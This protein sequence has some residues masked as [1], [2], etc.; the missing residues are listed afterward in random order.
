MN[1]R[2]KL[3]GAMVLPAIALVV[4][5]ATFRA[6]SGGEASATVRHDAMAAD[7]QRLTV[8]LGDTLRFDQ[9]AFTVNA[10][11]PVVITVRN[12]GSTNHDFVIPSMPAE[13]VVIRNEGG[14]THGDG[15]AIVGHPRVNGEVTVQ[16]TPTQ[17]G[18]YEFYCSVTGHKEAGMTGTIIVL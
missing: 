3:L 6:L 7:A 1:R 11:R 12:V 18:T 14:H 8:T 5:A 2:T 16:F 13:D 15:T 10:G 17:P 4:V 9:P